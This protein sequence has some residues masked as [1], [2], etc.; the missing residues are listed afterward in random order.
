MTVKKHT[1]LNLDVDLLREAQRALGTRE[2]T[3]TIHRALEDVVAR[4]K[5]RQLLDMGLGDL[6]PERL[7]DMRRNRP[8]ESNTSDSNA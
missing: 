3:E 2:A 6:S 1:T 8:F 4:E 7:E 5:R